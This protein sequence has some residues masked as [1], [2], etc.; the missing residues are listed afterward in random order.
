[1]VICICIQV[2]VFLNNFSRAASYLQ[3]IISQLKFT[4]MKKFILIIV[5]AT[6]VTVAS[7]KPNHQKDYEAGNSRFG[8]Q[9]NDNRY[10]NSYARNRKEKE[11]KLRQNDWFYEQKIREVKMNYRLRESKKYKQIYKLQKQ[12]E[13]AAKRIEAYYASNNVHYNDHHSKW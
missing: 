8:T 9:K 7:A 11:E 10:D 6:F 3:K 12:R 4:K 1:M 13:E 5:A 2:I